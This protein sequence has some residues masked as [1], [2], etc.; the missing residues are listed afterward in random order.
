MR[1]VTYII[2]AGETIEEAIAGDYVRVRSS[3]VDLVIENPDAGEKIEVSQGDDFQFTPFKHLRISHQDAAAQTIKLTV[4][5]GKRAGSAKVGGSVTVAGS[6]PIS[7]LPA[8]QG[9]YVQNR[10]SLTNAVQTLLAANAARRAAT[11]QNNDAVQ[12]MRYTLDGSAPTATQGFR[13]QPGESVDLPSYA[14]TGAVKAIMEAAT[15]TA[16]NVEFCEG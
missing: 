1:T 6:V 2:P 8:Q 10:V 13:L 14:C 16:N 11:L 7:N 15:A 12:V 9:A 4:A 5:S 3:A